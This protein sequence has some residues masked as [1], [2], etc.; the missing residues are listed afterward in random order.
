MRSHYLLRAQYYIV[1]EQGRAHHEVPLLTESTVLYR[2]G[3]RQS[4]S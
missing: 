3:A 4:T 1:P 2:T